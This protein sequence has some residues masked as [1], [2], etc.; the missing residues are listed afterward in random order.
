M[1]KVTGRGPSM[2][3]TKYVKHGLTKEEQAKVAAY[4]KDNEMRWKVLFSLNAWRPV[5]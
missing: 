5:K 4:I 1:S 3:N 2:R